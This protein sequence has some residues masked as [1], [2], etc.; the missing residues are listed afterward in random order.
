MRILSMTRRVVV[1]LVVTVGLVCTFASPS[2][3][4]TGDCDGDGRVTVD[5]VLQAV[6]ASIHGCAAAL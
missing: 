5:E 6:G 3:A 4:C 2:A 1:A